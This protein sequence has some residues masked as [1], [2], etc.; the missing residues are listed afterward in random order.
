M[1]RIR[2]FKTIHEVHESY[3]NDL[4]SSIKDLE[5]LIRVSVFV[6][7]YI[8]AKGLEEDI[9]KEAKKEGLDFSEMFG[10]KSTPG[11]LFK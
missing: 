4:K 7:A 3:K 9:M 11:G 6:L 5:T 10:G 8:E 1:A 2:R